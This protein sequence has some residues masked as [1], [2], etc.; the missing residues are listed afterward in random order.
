MLEGT[1]I[2]ASKHLP[3]ADADLS[4][5]ERQYLLEAFDSGWIN[6]SGPFVNRFERAM[7]EYCGVPHARAWANGTVALHLALLALGI[8]PGD[9]V[10]VPS[11]TYIATANAV[12]YCGATPVFADCDAH[13]WNLTADTIRPLLSERTRTIITVHLYGNPVDID[14]ILA[15]ADKHGLSVVED[16]AEAHGFSSSASFAAIRQSGFLKSRPQRLG[17]TGAHIALGQRYRISDEASKY[18]PLAAEK[19]S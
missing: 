7:A 12:T 1:R 9:E 11:L 17:C 10:I 3:V 4:G 14:P 13:T 2:G 15:L 8:G 19:R 5:N 18:E 6:G 16:A